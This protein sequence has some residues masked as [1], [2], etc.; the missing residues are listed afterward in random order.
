MLICMEKYREEIRHWL[1]REERPQAYLA[2]K[3]GITP[4]CLNQF[5]KEKR[6]ISLNVWDKLKKAMNRYA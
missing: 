6:G 4:A 2:K 1:E 3:A 5:L